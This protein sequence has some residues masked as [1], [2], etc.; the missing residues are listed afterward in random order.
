[1]GII[2]STTRVLAPVNQLVTGAGQK[3][4]NY[5][6]WENT[7]TTFKAPYIASS[8][9][10]LAKYASSYAT[11]VTTST[12]FVVGA[13]M[14]P[15]VYGPLANCSPQLRAVAV[16]TTLGALW[17]F[18][19]NHAAGVK[20]AQELKTVEQN[21]ATQTKEQRLKASLIMAFGAGAIGT[22]RINPVELVSGLFEFREES[23]P[24]DKAV[25]Q[26]DNSKKSTVYGLRIQ[27]KVTK[28]VFYANVYYAGGKIQIEAPEMPVRLNE[29]SLDAIA[30]KRHSRYELV[31]PQG[32]ELTLLQE[33][34]NRMEPKVN[35]HDVSIKRLEN[36]NAELQAQ[37][38]TL[39]TLVTRLTRTLEAQT[40]KASTPAGETGDYVEVIAPTA[41]KAK[42]K[43]A[44]TETEEPPT[45]KAAS[46][47]L[48]HL[49]ETLA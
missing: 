42:G 41:R 14:I 36:S 29:Y 40:A 46:A 22:A 10:C 25:V 31:P 43:K 47:V 18:R 30:E 9:D 4:K 26:V 38:Q 3:V 32:K 44:P 15:N 48:N 35:A 16:A 19:R 33:R 1:M 28:D 37:V 24:A 27:D 45:G 12:P 13:S 34:V 20:E 2:Q 21:R 23:F 11:Y 6:K 39:T 17:F 49:V 5:A 8:L 7:P